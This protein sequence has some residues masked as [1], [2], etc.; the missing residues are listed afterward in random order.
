MPATAPG[1]VP[2]TGPAPVDAFSAAC[3]KYGLDEKSAR[4][5]RDRAILGYERLSEKMSERL[6][7]Q[8]PTLEKLLGPHDASRVAAAQAAATA[9]AAATLQ[10]HW[11]VQRQEGASWVD[12]DPLLPTATPGASV[13]AL[14]GTLDPGALPAELCHRVEIRVVT[15]RWEA[16]AVKESVILRQALR[17]SQLL[18]Q[19]VSL[20]HVPLNF[21]GDFNLFKE[22]DPFGRVKSLALAQREWVPILTVGREQVIGSS[23]SIEGATSPKPNLGMMAAQGRS[24]KA[25]AAD[26][27]GA[28]DAREDDTPRQAA[29][30]FTAEWLEYEI[31]VPG[32]A[33]TTVRR[34]V[35]DSF[36]P[37]ARAAGAI[38]Q[39]PLTSPEAKLDRAL[40]MLSQ[41][42]LL[43]M[44]CALSDAF[45]SHLLVGAMT[46]QAPVIGMVPKG[47]PAGPAEIEA[48]QVIQPFLSELYQVALIREA[49]SPA[50]GHTF[51]DRPMVMAQHHFLRR[52]A[53][54]EA[55]PCKGFDFVANGTAVHRWSP[56]APALVRM[57]QGV[58]DTNAEAILS[59]EGRTIGSAADALAVADERGEDWL[60]LTDPK[61]ARL[62]TLPLPDDVRARISQDLAAGYHVLCPVRA[63]AGGDAWAASWWRVNPETGDTLGIGG[64]GWGATMVEY[65]GTFLIVFV[66]AYGACQGIMAAGTNIS[67]VPQTQD[68]KGRTAIFCLGFAICAAALVVFGMLYMEALA[69]DAAAAGGG[70]GAFGGGAGGGTG[71]GAFGGGGGGGAFGG[72]AGGG[73]GGAF[74]GG[75][76]GGGGG[77]FGG[78]AGGGGGALSPGAYTGVGANPFGATSVGANPFAATEIGASPF[79]ATQAGSGAAADSLV[80]G[81][82]GFPFGF[83]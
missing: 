79:A 34:Q 68:Q 51:H 19:S 65:A 43:V 67:G 14:T 72:G 12:L 11:W 31:Q 76:G 21:P 39:R 26:V 10:D 9:A 42:Q 28:L 80:S 78:G 56:V 55:V 54:G 16:G 1:A 37:G 3:A 44:P 17:P 62:G 73:G 36:G 13:A 53:K 7:S 15:E 59:R 8:T 46:A 70:G 6:A 77:A 2:A 82:A 48:A 24:A 41:T 49:R 33:P 58:V 63:P 45:V 5:G 23:V 27:T 81:G 60:P 69:A 20:A 30:E 50:R 4:A 22:A 38:A 74:G 66:L 52:G 75:A 18:G 32:E 71:G 61:D 29:S 40:A 47:G 25:N 35:F 83:P 57:T 64:N